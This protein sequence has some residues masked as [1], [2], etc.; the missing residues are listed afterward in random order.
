MPWT[1]AVH[2]DLTFSQEALQL[3][4]RQILYPDLSPLDIFRS[5]DDI[6]LRDVASRYRA[7]R[8]RSV[9]RT[10]GSERKISCFSRDHQFAVQAWRRIPTKIP[11]EIRTQYQS[12]NG[13]KGCPVSLHPNIPTNFSNR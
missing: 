13:Q 10:T 8:R 4:A 3:I 9:L 2:F 5:C 6:E 7:R 11:S 12:K 1:G